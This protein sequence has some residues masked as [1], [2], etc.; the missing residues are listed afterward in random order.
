MLLRACD[1]QAQEHIHKQSAV[2][3]LVISALRGRDRRIPSTGYV[4]SSALALIHSKIHLKQKTRN[5]LL[6]ISNQLFLNKLITQ[7]KALLSGHR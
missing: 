4:E 7:I 2:A 5:I 1:Y 3:L 6:S